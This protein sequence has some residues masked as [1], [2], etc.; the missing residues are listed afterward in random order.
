MKPKKVDRIDPKQ[1]PRRQDFSA[2]GSG[3]VKYHTRSM[4]LP[5]SA[6]ADY[7]AV[8]EG[9]ASPRFIRLTTNNIAMDAEL[10]E[11]TRLSIGAIIQPLA[12]LG[13]GEEPIPII[14]YEKGP[15]RCGKCLAY[16]NPFFQFVEQ[17]NAFICN[18]CEMRNEVPDEYRCNLDANGYRRDRH[19]RPELC[20]G[21]VEFE[22]G[23]DFILRPIQDPCFLFVIDVSYG[24][25]VSGLVAAAIQSVRTAIDQLGSM[26]PADG[27]VNRMKVG[28]ITYD[29][30]VHFYSLKEGRT[31][32][33]MLVMS[34][35]DEPFVPCP[36]D[37]LLV[38][39]R[40]EE[41]RTLLHATLDMLASVYERSKVSENL[42]VFGAAVAAA[43]EALQDVGG[44][45][46][47][48]MQSNLPTIGVGKL[49]ARD[50]ISLYYTPREKSLQLP[51][52]AFYQTLATNC[53]ENAITVDLFVCANGYVDLATVGA[54]TEKTGGQIFLYP[55]FNARKDGLALQRDVFHDVTRLTGYDGVMIVRAST[56]LKVVEHF[57][58]FYHRNVQEME[59]PSIDADKTFGIRLEHE[60]KLKDKT[61]ACIQ[62]AML[63]TTA[64]GHRRIRVHTISV[65]VTSVMSNI[66]RFADLDAIINLSLKQAVRQLS[67]T[68]TCTEAQNAL[69]MACIDSLYVYR[70]FCASATSAGQLILPE[71]LKLLP[72][73]TLGLVKHP[74]FQDGLAADERSF[75]FSFVNSMPCYV[76]VAFVTP[77]LF[78]LTQFEGN[79]CVPDENGR[80]FLPMPLTLSSEY[81]SSDGLYLLDDGRYMYLYIGA[82]LSQSLLEEVFAIQGDGKQVAGQYRIRHVPNQPYALSSRI[83]VLIG[84][85]RKNKP[86]FQNL[87]II[88]R[89]SPANH[90]ITGPSPSPTNR[91]G[92]ETFESLDESLFFSHLIEDAVVRTDGKGGKEKSGSSSQRAPNTMSYVDFLCFC[93]KRI[94][95]KFL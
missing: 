56:G 38:H 82:D 44:G 62:C 10:I 76:S 35:I 9:N 2:A 1:I 88:S 53:A 64:S 93:H 63:Y 20:R 91:A 49:E 18:L 37:E 47:L 27:T 32:P 31:E 70:K 67:D 23:S 58:A 95:A 66:F 7:V 80:V 30:S 26:Q 42:P 28:L 15:V 85:L 8:D 11:Q 25:V 12:N 60:G 54:L 87:Q 29:Q 55:G 40:D 65:P 84:T 92:W 57:G 4:T 73:C 41:K 33:M 24:A 36:A 16:V 75:L 48:I 61:E 22:V 14:H 69:V 34:D 90:P 94:Q 83:N 78:S 71:P 51:Q 13:D 5:P 52:N 79:A 46:V 81:I 86:Q 45:K 3:P 89:R 68:T 19:D 6:T 74:L 72:L 17:G 59:L 43:T 50:Q 39:V 21:S 77:R